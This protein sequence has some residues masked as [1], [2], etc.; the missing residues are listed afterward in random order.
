MDFFL[1]CL[2]KESYRL[3]EWVSVAQEIA[4]SH[5]KEKSTPR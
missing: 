4:Y 1:S 5:L 3:N 2:A